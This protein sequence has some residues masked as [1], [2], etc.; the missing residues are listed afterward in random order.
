MDMAVD[1]EQGLHFGTL[2]PYDLFIL[3]IMLPQVMD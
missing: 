2:N 3:D 1:G